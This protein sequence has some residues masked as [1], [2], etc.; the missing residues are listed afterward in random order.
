M[1]DNWILYSIISTFGTATAFIILKCMK[2]TNIDIL[3]LVGLSYFVL[4]LFAI[5]YMIINRKNILSKKYIGKFSPYIFLLVI[6]FAFMHF[7]NP[8]FISKAVDNSPNIG[9]SHLIVNFN[10]ILTLIAGYFLF[11]QKIN[12]YSF[13]GVII[14]F[15]GLA[16]VIYNQ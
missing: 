9:Y 8:Y 1:L 4:S 2:Q 3:I 5:I 12:L 13:L 6:L 7:F 10:V 16:F 11:G 14:A 15:I